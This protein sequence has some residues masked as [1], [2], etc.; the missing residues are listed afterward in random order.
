MLRRQD[1]ESMN[2]VILACASLTRHVDAAQEKMNTNYPVI[3]LDRKYHEDPKQMREHL[4]EALQS[5]PS[6]VGTVL[7]A[8]GFCGGSWEAVPL[9]K[10]LVIPRVDDCV[11]LLLHTDNSWYPNLK[12]P[13]HLYLFDGDVGEYS[14]EAMR[15]RLC[16]QYGEENG[17]VIF[18]FMFANYTNADIIDT[19]VYDC[20]AESYLSEARKSAELIRSPLGYVEGSNLL[21]EKL[22]SGRWDRQFIVAEP[23]RQLSNEDFL[24]L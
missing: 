21:L 23:G 22:V 10:R 9:E 17:G 13:G 5:L 18:D 19:R 3:Y 11:T 15:G 4:I 1:G 7:V 16:A 14:L 8:M 6:D 20:R 12:E 24:P 2:T